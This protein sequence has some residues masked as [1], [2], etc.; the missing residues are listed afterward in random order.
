MDHTQDINKLRQDFSWQGLIVFALPV[1]LLNLWLGV[2]QMIDSAISSSLI[3][4]NALAAIDVCYPILSIE[5]GV[6]AMLGA[7]A[8]AIIGKKLGE[9]RSEEARENLTTIVALAF[10]FGII[11][12]IFVYIFR[13]PIL[14]MLG[15]TK[16]LMPYCDTYVRV[17]VFFGAFYLVQTMFQLILVVGGKPGRAFAMTVLAGAVE[18]AAAFIFIKFFGL[19]IA[20]SALGAGC[21]MTASCIGSVLALRD[22]KFELHYGKFSFSW[23]LLGESC[24]LGLADL[25]MSAA[26]GLITAL[27]N[28]VSIRYFGEDGCAAITILLYCQWIFAAGMYG[29]TKG[30][31]PIISYDVGERN[32]GKIR[33]YMKTSF[34]CIGVLSVVLF[35]LP[36]VLKVPLTNLYTAPNTPVW[37]M[38]VAGFFPF[39]IQFLFYGVNTLITQFFTSANDG[40]R[41]TLLAT[42]RTIVLP[43][44]LLLVLPNLVGGSVIWYISALQEVITFVLALILFVNGRRDF[45]FD[46]ADGE[47]QKAEVSVH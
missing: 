20:G 37:K 39:S 46:E 13:T 12:E 23:G 14:G 9:G 26:L 25:F 24:W 1:I 32:G 17:H 8:C 18:I 33:R 40:K 10:I 36:N 29:Y 3:N 47:I 5:E 35:I 45:V 16:I 21:G 6:A 30:I 11:Y 2:Y 7:G 27:Y 31:G 4:T 28:I 43:I 22:K 34:I 19:G 42:V 44:V 41:A 38:A 15:A